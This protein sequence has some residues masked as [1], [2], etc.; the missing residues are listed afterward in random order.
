M[1][2]DLMK[3]AVGREFEF[4]LTGYTHIGTTIAIMSFKDGSGEGFLVEV[5]EQSERDI[6]ECGAASLAVIA[7]FGPGTRFPNAQ[8][9]IAQLKDP[10]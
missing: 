1:L 10:S 4:S 7:P 3:K 5:E 8:S 6:P 9:A 2:E